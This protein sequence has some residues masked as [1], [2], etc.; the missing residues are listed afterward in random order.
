MRRREFIKGAAC[1][2]AAAIGGLRGRAATK[3]A[4]VRA[5]LVHL[6]SNFW[7]DLPEP[8][9]YTWW[10]RKAHVGYLRTEYAVWREY[11]DSL[12]A[13]GFN[14][15]VVDV[16][17][18]VVYPSHPELAL[19]GSWS[20]D[21]LRAELAYL[22]KL[23][24]EPVPKLNLSATHNTWMKG[25][26]QRMTTP[27]Y[28]RFVDDLVRDVADIFDRPRLI[29]LGMDEETCNHQ[30]VWQNY[31]LVIVRRGETWWTDFL[32]AVE[33]VRKVGARPWC[34]SDQM[35]YEHDLFV[36]KMPKDVLQCPWG[37]LKN[38]KHPE[39]L[40]S[41]EEMSDL[42]YEFIADVATYNRNPDEGCNRSELPFGLDFC[43]QDRFRAALRGFI[44]CPWYMT[45]SGVPR[46]KYLDS[47]AFAAGEFA[48]RGIGG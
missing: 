34:F 16:G 14:M 37:V 17:D 47:I 10:D 7:T 40:R 26:R 11:V 44:L 21:K 27:D 23:G 22:R 2:G 46:K 42:G 36:R 4:L 8:P 9:D 31:G 19:K 13:H 43:L 45:V 32:K 28:H 29:H 30:A 48:K 24:L 12:A 25:W 33:S 41:I 20:V 38:D 6:A 5:A 35:W 3:P 15:V 18:A 39:W 1:L